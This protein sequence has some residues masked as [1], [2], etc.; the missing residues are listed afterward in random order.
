MRSEL[1]GK[2]RWLKAELHAHCNLDPVDYRGCAYSAEELIR[3]AARLDY[4]VLAI[5]CHNLDVWTEALSAYASSLGI[6]LIPGMEV[7]VDRGCHTLVYNFKTTAEKL[8]TLAGIR[9]FSR[10]DTLVIAPHPYFPSTKCLWRRL[11]RNLEVFDAIEISGFYA[12]G[13]DFNRRARRIA[14]AYRKPLVGNCDVHQLWQLGSTC[15]WILAEPAKESI[16]Q[17]IKQGRTRVE[18]AALSYAQVAR[19]WVTSLTR[20]VFP[21]PKAS[22]P[23]ERPLL[24]NPTTKG[25]EPGVAG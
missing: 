3:A 6:L 18:S 24:P 21:Y 22:R 1:C 25:H 7:T 12:P 14:A 20:A 16:I 11:D 4:D 13:L 10:A 9:S 5:T 23:C 2:E 8:G 19:W 17:A 15:T